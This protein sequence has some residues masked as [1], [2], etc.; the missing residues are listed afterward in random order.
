MRS[1]RYFK[2]NAIQLSLIA[3]VPP[4]KDSDGP[5][6]GQRHSVVRPPNHPRARL[7]DRHVIRYR[8]IKANAI[9]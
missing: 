9:L 8:G 7:H 1:E 4:M 5:M 3:F 2:M 6:N